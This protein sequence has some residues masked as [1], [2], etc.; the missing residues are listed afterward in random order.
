MTTSATHTGRSAASQATDTR[1]VSCVEPGPRLDADDL[2]RRLHARADRDRRR[3][4]DLLQ[5]VVH[6]HRDPGDLEELP[7]EERHQRERE[8][9]VRDGRPERALLRAFL[10]DVDP[11]VVVGEVGE[12]VRPAAG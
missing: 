5:A 8:V 6:R 2:G 12:A 7:E 4:P 9:A 11:L 3:E 1:T 10:V